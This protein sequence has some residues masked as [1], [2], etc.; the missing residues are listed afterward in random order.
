MANFVGN[1]EI[2]SKF[3]AKIII[4][5]D[6]ILVKFPIPV[7]GD[8]ICKVV[9]LDKDF[10]YL[11]I[12]SGNFLLDTLVN[13]EKSLSLVL[14]HLKRYNIH[15]EVVDKGQIKIPTQDILNY[16]PN[17]YIQGLTGK[18]TIDYS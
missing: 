18:L 1:L 13:S 16:F 7:I 9:E 2:I 12:S 17:G 11:V 8:V 5:K 15:G 14:N 4:G 3:N 10:I 6:G